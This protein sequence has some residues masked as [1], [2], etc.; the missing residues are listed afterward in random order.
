[1]NVLQSINLTLSDIQMQLA[2]ISEQNTQRDSALKQL[3]IDIKEIKQS[4]VVTD[5]NNVL[6]DQ[7]FVA[8][9]GDF[10]FAWEVPQCVSGRTLIT[11][12]IIARSE[13][14][15][16]PETLTGKVS[17]LSDVYSCGVVSI[18]NL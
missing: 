15:Y 2:T 13:G 18:I 12:P 17:P 4:K 16:A 7:H 10:G 6:L 8:K 14:Y 5:R 11:A 1:M 3:E 9:V